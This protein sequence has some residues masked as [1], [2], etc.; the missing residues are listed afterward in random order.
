MILVR[1][2]AAGPSLA[3]ATALLGCV[4]SIPAPVDPG[5]LPA[6]SAGNYGVLGRDPCDDDADCHACAMGDG[7]IASTSSCD[8]ASACDVACCRGRCT[9]VSG[10]SGL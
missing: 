6:C 8:P 10:S 9:V 7:C 4:A 1:V 5:M 3:I 2:P